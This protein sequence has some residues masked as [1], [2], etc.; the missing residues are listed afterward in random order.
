[1][2]E[3]EMKKLTFDLEENVVDKLEKEAKHNER[4]V[5]A[6]LRVILKER[7]S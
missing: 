7:Y 1:M 3:K 6:Q 2:G 4:T 5:S